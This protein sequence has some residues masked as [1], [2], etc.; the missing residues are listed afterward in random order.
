MKKILA[1][2]F[3]LITISTSA[4]KQ[5]H[6]LV[7]EDLKNDNK[8]VAIPKDEPVKGDDYIYSVTNVKPEF[9]GGQEKFFKFVA[10]NFV[11]PEDADQFVKVFVS[12]IVEKDGSLTNIKVLRETGYGIGNEA[13][14]VLKSSPKWKPAIHSGKPVRCS[15]T[16]PISIVNRKEAK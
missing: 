9:P 6:E 5:P 10:T 11:I 3:L 8:D 1:M 4:Q 15:Y 14:R 12:F 2:L 13:V 7:T 16:V